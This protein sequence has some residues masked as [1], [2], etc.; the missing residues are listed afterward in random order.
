M[1]RDK[2]GFRESLVRIKLGQW[3][4]AS[5]GAKLHISTWDGRNFVCSVGLRIALKTDFTCEGS[6]SD[7]MTV[8]FC[9]GSVT[10]SENAVKA[11]V[12]KRKLQRIGF[13]YGVVIRRGISFEKLIPNLDHR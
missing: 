5:F 2:N 11:I 7:V 8:D 9:I 6:G 13:D 1:L 10:S 4:A 3:T 12:L